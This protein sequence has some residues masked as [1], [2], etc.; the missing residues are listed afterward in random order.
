MLTYLKM[1]LGA[2]IVF[3]VALGIG[4]IFGVKHQKSV[5]AAQVAEAKITILK[6]GK[7]VD[8]K[9]FDADDT[10]LCTLLGGC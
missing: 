5:V 1:G 2:L 9:V 3:P 4:F 8:D 7:R 10:T 6:D